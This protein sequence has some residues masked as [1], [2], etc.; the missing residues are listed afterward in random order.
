M[1]L[2]WSELAC[3]CQANP[4]RQGSRPKFFKNHL[5]HAIREYHSALSKTTVNL[6]VPEL[7]FQYLLE[8]YETALP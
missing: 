2:P 8:T 3:A 1:R 4:L 7:S 5:Y 6:F